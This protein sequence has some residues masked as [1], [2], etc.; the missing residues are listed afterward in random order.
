[1]C[2]PVLPLSSFL[3]ST[4]L[5]FL[6][7]PQAAGLEELDIRGCTRL[8]PASI[9][10]LPA[11][12]L[13]RLALGRSGWATAPALARAV[14]RWGASLEEVRRA[15]DPLRVGFVCVCSDLPGPLSKCQSQ[16]IQCGTTA[17]D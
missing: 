1:M 2:G 5:L 4:C 11:A 13:R 3:F 10:R 15:R 9:D 12:A 7:L 8:T 6:A 14:E 16:Y 17:A